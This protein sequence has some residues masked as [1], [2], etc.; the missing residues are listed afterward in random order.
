[1]TT[2]AIRI[3]LGALTLGLYTGPAF[4]QSD[5]ATDR[6]NPFLEAVTGGT[7]SVNLRLRL[8]LVDQDG[9]DDSAALTSRLRLGYTTR[10]YE[11]WS[12]HIDVEDIRAANDDG[13]NAA[14]FNSN[15]GKAVIADPED[16]ELNQLYANYAWEEMSANLRF[17]RQRVKLDDDRFVGNV[18]WRQNEQTF[19]AFTFSTTAIEDFTIM[20]GYI[21][22]INRIFGPDA[23]ADFES[24]SHVFNVAY[25]G[26]SCGKLVL[27]AY[28]LDF[29]NSPANSSDTIGVRFSGKH[30]LNE[31]YT[32]GYA[33]S[34]ADQSEAGD[35]PTDYD[36]EYYLIDVSLAKK[37]LGSIGIGYEVLGSDNSVA[38]FQTPLATGHKF[39]GWADVFLTTPAAGLEDLY[40]YASCTMPW[41]VKGRIIYHWF[42]AE[43][44]GADYGEELDIILSKKIDSN[45]SVTGKFADF[46]GDPGFA[47]RTK[48]WLQTTFTF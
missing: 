38:S 42:E 37:E 2:K 12:F 47:D 20:Y 35:N 43:D 33:L 8:E 44:G 7:I 24:D 32:L 23:E 41:D 18:G 4:A 31:E 11:G 1:M 36:T 16:T 46:N 9:F 22:D 6:G 45:W 48:F 10:E 28:L 25:D 21:W 29:D 3:V 26:L 13:Y 27:F 34:Y 30:A 17:G 5:E 15:P 39:N 40:V 14:G 19:D